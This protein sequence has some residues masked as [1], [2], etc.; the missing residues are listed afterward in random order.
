MQNRK[1]TL[2]KSRKMI[3]LVK[4]GLLFAIGASIATV[5]IIAW[6]RAFRVQAV[7]QDKFRT[8]SSF[9]IS[10]GMKDDYFPEVLDPDGQ[11]PDRGD[12]IRRVEELLIDPATGK[13]S[14]Y[15]PKTKSG[16]RIKHTLEHANRFILWSPEPS[17]GGKTVDFKE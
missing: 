13:K 12:K 3:F 5:K 6:D 17:Y 4:L 7:A 1:K 9:I 15:R 2:S 11:I 8:L 14:I 10:E 16:E